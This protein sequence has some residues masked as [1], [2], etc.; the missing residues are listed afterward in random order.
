[1]VAVLMLGSTTL[2]AQKFGRIDYEAIIVTMP[3]FATFQTDLQKVYSDFSEHI[4][5]MQVERNRKMDEAQ[6]LPEGTS[7]TTRQLRAREIMELEQRIN[8]YAQT[9]DQGIQQAQAELIKPLRDKADAAIAKICKAQ[10]IIVVFQTGS[11]IYIDESQTTDITA[12]VKTELGIPADA[13][14]PAGAPGM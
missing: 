10:S 13:V 9:A 14:P 1:M 2:F 3:E 12:A 6:N 11:V 8:D 5:G 4:Q 7:E